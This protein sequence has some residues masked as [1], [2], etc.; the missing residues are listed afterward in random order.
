MLKEPRHPNLMIWY[1]W[2]ATFTE[3]STAHSLGLISNEKY[4]EF[5]EITRKT[6]E[7]GKF[8]LDL[9]T[10]ACKL[11]YELEQHRSALTKHYESEQAIF[12]TA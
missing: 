10:E 3:A 7:S 4:E 6:Q 9:R 5:C 11:E 2:E 8:T 12:L 1:Y